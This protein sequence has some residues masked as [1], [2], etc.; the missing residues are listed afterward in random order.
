MHGYC[1]RGGRQCFEDGRT[2]CLFGHAAGR[3]SAGHSVRLICPT[4]RSRRREGIEGRR[5]P[6]G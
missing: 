1:G 2:R 5:S 3:A 6:A 4:G